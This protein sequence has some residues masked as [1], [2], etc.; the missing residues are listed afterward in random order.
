MVESVDRFPPK[1]QLLSLADR[2][3]L[4]QTQ[5]EV[6]GAASLERVATHRGCV[7][8][9][10]HGRLHPA[11][12][13]RFDARARVRVLET[14]CAALCRRPPVQNSA[15]GKRRARISNVGT[16]VS[17]GVVVSIEVI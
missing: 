11:H 4:E 13:G 10:S 7:R 8:Q 2:K 15:A 6:I 3:R 14:G 9:R 5:I 1:L 17:Y 12:T 16:V